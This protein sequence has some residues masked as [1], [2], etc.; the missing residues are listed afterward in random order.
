MNL[1]RNAAALETKRVRLTRI[2]LALNLRIW[3]L[4]MNSVKIR[5]LIIRS[6]AFKMK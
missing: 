4:L 2:K 6:L 3:R 5:N 1:P